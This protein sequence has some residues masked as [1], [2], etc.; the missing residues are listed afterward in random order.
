[1]IINSHSEQQFTLG[2]IGK[3][4]HE[5]YG[6][7]HARY[8]QYEK[9]DPSVAAT[10]PVGLIKKTG[11]LDW[12]VTNRFDISDPSLVV[13][14]NA[15]YVMPTDGQY[16]WVTVDGV[17]LQQL[18]NES[19]NWR[20]GETFVWSSTGKIKNEGPGVVVARRVNE[21]TT[22]TIL[23][24]QAH[25]TIEGLSAGAVI[26]ALESLIEDIE[27]LQEDVEALKDA[28]QITDT[29]K[30]INQQLKVLENRLKAEEN[31]RKSADTALNNRI[32]GLNFATLGQLN[33]AVASLEAQIAQVAATLTQSLNQT[34]EIA[35]EALNK[36]N[37]ALSVPIDEIWNQISLILAL[38]NDMKL[39]PKGKFP[40]VDGMVPPNLVYHDD[41]SLIFVETY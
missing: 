26:Q 5:H 8:V 35:L 37:Q 13:G 28:A 1:M 20:L 4:Y 27:Q 9:M 11:K 18:A 24:G 7:I 36:A 41:G 10:C 17:N 34:H 32:S 30:A 40:V 2:S 6:L 22:A 12:I 29:L 19:E 23:V 14:I 39:A 3:F 25:V 31:A 21:P 38:I 33:A 16:G 15:S